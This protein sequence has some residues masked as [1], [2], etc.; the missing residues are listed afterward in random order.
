[1]TRK[2]D[3]KRVSEEIFD[4]LE[5]IEKDKQNISIKEFAKFSIL[6]KERN[7]P[8]TR[9][10]SEFDKL[11]DLSNEFTSRIN[12]YKPFN[13]VNDNG[14]VVLTMPAIFNN[15]EPTKD[16]FSD[17]LSEF[18]TVGTHQLAHY[19]HRAT[20]GLM[21]AIIKSQDKSVIKEKREEFKKIDEK[22]KETL[23]LISASKVSE[24]ST[25]SGIKIKLTF[26]D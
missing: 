17:S 8:I 3:F 25:D 12:P 5:Q 6:Y 1:M 15:V 4:Q 26:D 22:A 21:G 14:E 24:I 13:I 18:N 9:F 7:V 23:G 20:R 11:K 16:E 2:D 10:S 19:R